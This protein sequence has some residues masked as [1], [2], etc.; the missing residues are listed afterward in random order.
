M[1]AARSNGNRA[2][3]RSWLR[4]YRV[5][6]VAFALSL[7]LGHMTSKVFA[8][9]IVV[10][11]SVVYD[12]QHTIGVSELIVSQCS[13]LGL[14][15]IENAASNTVLMGSG[16]ATE[17]L[18]NSKNQTTGSGGANMNGGGGADCMVPG[19]VRSGATLTVGGGAGTD[20][21][22]NGPG[23]GGYTANSCSNATFYNTPYV[24]GTTSSPAFS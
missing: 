20:Y 17:W 18:W 16:S 11:S 23:P 13:G 14:T 7:G 12:K 15:S 2:G 8:A 3:R 10:N 9:G 22:F 19:G 21:C 6:L 24:T 4:R 1:R 5:F